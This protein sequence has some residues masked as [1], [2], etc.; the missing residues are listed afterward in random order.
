[1]ST[2][3]NA[4]TVKTDLGHNKT[5]KKE[6]WYFRPKT[7]WPAHA[8]CGPENDFHHSAIFC[9]L[10]IF[11]LYDITNDVTDDV[12]GA[13]RHSRRSRSR[14]GQVWRSTGPTPRSGW[15]GTWWSIAAVGDALPAS[16]LLAFAP[17]DLPHDLCKS[18]NDLAVLTSWRRR[19][20]LH[21][22]LSTLWP[23]NNHNLH[24]YAVESYRVR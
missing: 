1:M 16:A 23:E 7:G 22:A 2:K 9:R 6:C 17:D 24:G 21:K 19:W 4:S 15:H 18:G 3:L 10:D 13:G 11:L 20:A 14:A 8:A 12:T 5:D